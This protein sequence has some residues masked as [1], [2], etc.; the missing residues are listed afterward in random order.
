MINLDKILLNLR[1]LMLFVLLLGCG[2]CQARIILWPP[3]MVPH[4]PH[5]PQPEPLPK[6]VQPKPEQPSK[7]EKKK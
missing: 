3:D 5:F 1:Y 7:P 6:P 4:P 2:K